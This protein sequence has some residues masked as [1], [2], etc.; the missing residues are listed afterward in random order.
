MTLPPPADG[1]PPTWPKRVLFLSHG[2]NLSGAA[3]HMTLLGREMSAQGVQFGIA[4][5]NLDPGKPLGREAYE[6]SGFEVFPCDFAGYGLTP[7]TLRKSWQASG[8]LKRICQQFKPDLLHVHA[9]TLCLVAR[10]TRLPYVT[11]FNIN[12][13]GPNKI[14]IARLANKLT[15]TAFGRRSMAISEQ[16]V[17]SLTHT[18]GIPADRVRRITYAPDTA[19]FSPATPDRR[20]AARRELKLPDEAFVVAVVARLEARKN[21]QLVLDA[22]AP[23]DTLPGNAPPVHLLFAGG[24]VGKHGQVLREQIDRLGLTD[25][26]HL[27]GHR[28]PQQV[29]DAADLSVLPSRLEGFGLVVVESMLSGVVPLRTRGE[30]AEQIE[31]GVSGV[32][33]SADDPK[34]LAGEIAKLRDDPARRE[35]MAEAA[36]R[37]ALERFGLAQMVDDVGR[38]Y[39]EALADHGGKK[40]G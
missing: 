25:R 31:D 23:L 40:A 12:V 7:T 27:V 26:V 13:D 19:E 35:R 29:Y 36:R 21:H 18:L 30:G 5:R 33:I 22:M 1:P 37:R 9:P 15:P 20:A 14:R 4:A 24:D 11:T 17:P 16:M 32:L 8:Q 34:A 39:A 3:V 28:P 6:A 38:V 2:L 10:R